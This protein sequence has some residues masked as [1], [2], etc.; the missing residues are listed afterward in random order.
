MKMHLNTADFEKVLSWQKTL[1]VRIND[2]KRKN[3]AVWD[4]VEFENNDSE[5]IPCKITKLTYY[6]S[7]ADVY[8]ND[9]NIE[10]AWHDTKEETIAKCYEFYSP[11]EEKENGVVGIE[12]EC[13]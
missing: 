2:E 5:I 6:K 13:V 9:A 11:E 7:F 4:I 10:K 1:E 12:I 8:G 3:L